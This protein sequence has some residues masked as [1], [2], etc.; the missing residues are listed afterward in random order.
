[1]EVVGIVARI[2]EGVI[3]MVVSNSKR[4]SLISLIIHRNLSY[5]NLI[6]ITT[7]VVLVI[8]IIIV[9]I[10]LASSLLQLEKVGIHFN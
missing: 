10:R 8:K 5:S 9:S 6:A 7:F 3:N 1:M 2:R 4:I